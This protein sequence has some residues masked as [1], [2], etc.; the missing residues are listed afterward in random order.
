M[1][2]KGPKSPQF[3]SSRVTISLTKQPK[4]QQFSRGSH[5]LWDGNRPLTP[6]RACVKSADM[7]FGNDQ[8]FDMVIWKT[9]MNRADGWDGPIPN[10]PRALHEGRFIL[11]SFPTPLLQ[12]LKPRLP[13]H[14]IPQW[15]ATFLKEI[16]EQF[17][18]EVLTFED[19]SKYRLIGVP[20]YNNEDENRFKE[21][22]ESALSEQE[23]A[24]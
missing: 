4:Q 10:L 16:R 14:R 17:A 6:T 1:D 23:K 21:S 9:L 8:I 15:K 20:F 5:P 18:D 7:K 12:H 22:L 19:G 13:C 2:P 11:A 3:F 24:V